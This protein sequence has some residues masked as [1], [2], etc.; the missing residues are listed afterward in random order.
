[1][2]QVCNRLAARCLSKSAAAA[3]PCLDIGSLKAGMCVLSCRLILHISW[4][5][6]GSIAIGH[7]KPRLWNA[8]QTQRRALW[9]KKKRYQGR[10]GRADA[11]H[12]CGGEPH[13]YTAVLRTQQPQAL[14]ATYAFGLPAR[15]RL[16]QPAQLL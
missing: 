12:F 14:S 15:P 1:M 2:R 10:F 8:L 13:K 3:K 7:K 9:N 11:V 5:A 4:M 16:K 6:Q